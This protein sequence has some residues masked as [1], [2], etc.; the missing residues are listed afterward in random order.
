MMYSNAL[1]KMNSTPATQS[2]VTGGPIILV[3]IA[4]K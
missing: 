3:D 2:V 4:H 1:F